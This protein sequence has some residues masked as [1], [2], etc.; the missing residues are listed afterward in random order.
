LIFCQNWAVLHSG[1]ESNPKMNK[2]FPSSPTVS[3]IIPAH[4]GGPKIRRC[5]QAIL[6]A[7][8]RPEEIIVIDDGGP[9]G[10][11]L[12][13][14]SPGVKWIKNPV[15]L[16]PAHARNQGASAA[17]SDLLLFIDSDVVIPPTLIGRMVSC[18][19][20]HPKIAALFGSYDDDPG[21]NNFLSQYKNLFH[22]FTHQTSRQEAFTFW[23]GC[24][25]IYR[26]VF[27]EMKGFDER[28]RR[29][30]IEDIELGYRLKQAGYRIRL[31][32]DLQVTH[33]KRWRFF[34]LLKSDFF[35]R[36]LPWTDLI[37]R[38][39][40]FPNYLN[41]RLSDRLSLF[42]VYGFLVFFFLGVWINYRFWGGLLV[43]GLLF[44]LLNGS[45]YRFFLRKRGFWFT[46]KTIPWH[47]F[48]YFYCGLAF[49]WGLVRF[50]IRKIIFPKAG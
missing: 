14:E 46:L 24:G 9:K 32:K 50:L 7:T 43:L 5:L 19:R 13:P 22:H 44:L 27:L 3:V 48:Y 37:L 33:L 28:Y 42:V 21:E 49:S 17:Q 45:F 25:A 4:D 15:T 8:P 39:G 31:G 26:S 18:F 47:G 20:D 38:Y 41:I 36:A 34:S 23:A 30:S 1:D 11:L 12:P 40:R 10:S 35:D 16:G 29:P 2:S 6:Q